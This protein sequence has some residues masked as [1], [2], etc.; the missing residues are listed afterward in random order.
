M[1]EKLQDKN[2]H[3]LNSQ[4]RMLGFGGLIPFIFFMLCVLIPSLN[5]FSVEA[6]DVFRGYSIAILSFMAGALWPLGFLVNMSSPNRPVRQS[7]LLWGSIFVTIAGWGSFFLVAK[8][9]VFVSA[10]LFLVIWQIEQKTLLAK[11]YPDWY[12]VL[13]AQLTMVVAA[14]HIFVWLTL[15]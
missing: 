10:L 5:P 14:C 11:N 12:T 13:R 4:V 8:A 9:G 7:G 2:Q 15:S 6:L 3:S 1:T